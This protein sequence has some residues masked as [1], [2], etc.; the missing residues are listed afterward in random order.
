MKRIIAIIL[1]LF[2]FKPKVSTGICGEF[3]HGYGRL[4][5]NGEWEYP[6]CSTMTTTE[7][8]HDHYKIQ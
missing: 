4:D 3:N 2:G 5:P 6:L 8:S 1:K 7:V